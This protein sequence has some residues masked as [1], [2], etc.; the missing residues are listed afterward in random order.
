[1]SG[2]TL[3]LYQMASETCTGLEGPRRFSV[4]APVVLAHREPVAAVDARQSSLANFPM[5]LCAVPVESSMCPR[6][7]NAQLADALQPLT[8]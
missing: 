4:M 7:A 8:T 6:F 2:L 5:C 3:K 1:M